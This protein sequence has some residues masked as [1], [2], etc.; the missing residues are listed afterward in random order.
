MCR[1]SGST[2]LRLRA[3]YGQ[4]EGELFLW[5]R[6]DSV[7]LATLSV[8]GERGAAA[9]SLPLSVGDQGEPRAFL[10]RHFDSA[11]SSY[12]QCERNKKKLEGQEPRPH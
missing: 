6:F 7:S 9:W 2:P 8:N 11:L 1:L 4:R 12:A 3:G 5:L 10:D